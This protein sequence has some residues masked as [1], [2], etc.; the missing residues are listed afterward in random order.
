MNKEEIRQSVEV[1]FYRFNTLSLLIFYLVMAAVFAA[2]PFGV[3]LPYPDDLY[4]F[5]ALVGADTVAFFPFIIFFLIRWLSPLV[6]AQDYVKQEV[7][8]GTSEPLINGMNYFPLTLTIDGAEAQKTTHAFF[9][10]GSWFLGRYA[11]ISNFA[12]CNGEIA[13]DAKHDRILVLKSLNPKAEQPE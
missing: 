2:I 4:F 5:L 8:F 9:I 11:A 12:N 6:H 13:Y 3:G 10:Q 7:A 1:R